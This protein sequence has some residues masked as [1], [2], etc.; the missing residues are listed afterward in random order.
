MIVNRHSKETRYRHPILPHLQEGGQGGGAARIFAGWLAAT[1]MP[2]LCM[3]EAAPW[4]MPGE[5]RR[6][7]HGISGMSVSLLIMAV[8]T[9]SLCKPLKL[10][11]SFRANYSDKML[12][13]PLTATI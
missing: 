6:K 12:L 8:I 2:R 9:H 4:N 5:A 10:H 11:G 13:S 1:L 3:E 7:R